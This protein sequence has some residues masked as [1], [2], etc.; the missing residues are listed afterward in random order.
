LRFGTADWDDVE[1]GRELKPLVKGPIT[2]TDEIAF[3]IGGGAPIPRLTAHTFALKFY[4]RHPAWSFRDPASR[5]LEPIYAV[6]DN[7]E[8]ARPGTALSVRR[9]VPETGLADPYVNQFRRGRRL[10]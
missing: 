4:R 2:M 5:A 6:H 3:L 7:R 10:A 1:V 8:A 9:R